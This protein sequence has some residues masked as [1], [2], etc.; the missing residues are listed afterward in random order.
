V[1]VPGPSPSPTT[2]RRGLLV[3]LALGA[4]ILAYG[5]RGVFVDAT[6]T[7]P[8]ELARWVLGS[9]LAVDLLVV[10][11]T[12]VVG[13]AVRR[14]CPSPW[15]PTVRAALMAT[16]ALALVAWP[17]V[18]SYGQD[19]ANPSLLPRDHLAGVAAAIAAVWAVA[20][21]HLVVRSRLVRA[22]RH[23]AEASGGSPEG[24]Y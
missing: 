6:R 7:H 8:A 18:R 14:I 4:P 2:S 11:A 24:R 16:G 13:A 20:A 5:V 1:T 15:W 23:G 21:A 12:L 22:M 10:P 3:G 19:P 17:F 9:A